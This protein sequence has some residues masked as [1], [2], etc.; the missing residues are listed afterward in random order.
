MLTKKVG[1]PATKYLLDFGSRPWLLPGAPDC[2][3]P[4]YRE[5]IFCFRD[6]PGL[7]AARHVRKEYKARKGK[8]NRDYPVHNE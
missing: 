6:P 2:V 4:L 3:H 5:C 8:W 1:V 7:P